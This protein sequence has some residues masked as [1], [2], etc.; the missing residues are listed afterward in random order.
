MHRTPHSHRFCCW[1]SARCSFSGR[2]QLRAVRAGPRNFV[3][4]VSDAEHPELMRLAPSVLA[5]MQSQAKKHAASCRVEYKEPPPHNGEDEPPMPKN[6]DGFRTLSILRGES[7]ESSS[8]AN[9]D[10]GTWCGCSSENIE[11]VPC[12]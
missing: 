11:P 12:A 2:F 10:G 4:F 1:G 8:S 9:S 6:F 7:P 3:S 5:R